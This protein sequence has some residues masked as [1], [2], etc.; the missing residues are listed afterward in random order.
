MRAVDV[1]FFSSKADLSAL[2]SDVCFDPNGTDS[3]ELDEASTRHSMSSDR[4]FFV[5]ST[6]NVYVA[7]GWF[8]DDQSCVRETRRKA[9]GL[10]F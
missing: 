6:S 4:R 5:S 8:G 7:A 10:V 3:S 2:H 1:S 9:H